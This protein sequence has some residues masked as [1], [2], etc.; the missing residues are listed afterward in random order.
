M[1]SI[2][3]SSALFQ[4][5]SSSRFQPSQVAQFA[6]DRLDEEKKGFLEVE[7]VTGTQLEGVYETADANND[8]QL[9][10]EELEA[11]AANQIAERLSQIDHSS[12]LSQINSGSLF[13]D[14]SLSLVDA[15]APKEDSSTSSLVSFLAD[16]YGLG[17]Q[18]SYDS[19][20]YYLSLLA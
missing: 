16:A 1:V 10:Q 14:S 4:G 11:F 15:L 3:S 20:E 8:G 17:S 7:D 9:V 12:L 19:T 13:G 5:L 6:F 2:A 18:D